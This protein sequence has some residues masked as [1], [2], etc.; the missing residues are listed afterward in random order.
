M[1]TPRVLGVDDFLFLP[2]AELWSYPHRSRTAGSHRLASRSRS[3][4]VQKVVACPSGCGDHQP[5]SRWR[6]CGRARQGA[7]KARQVADRWHLLKNLSEDDAELL[8]QQAITTQALVQ[9]SAAEASPEAENRHNFAPWHSGRTK[10]KARKESCVFISSESNVVPPDPG[11]GSQKDRV[12]TIARKLGVSRQ[13]VYT[14][15][16]MRQPPARTRIN[17]GG[18]R[19]IDSYKEYLAREVERGMSQCAADVS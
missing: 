10:R 15:L 6:V 17:Q 16:Q 7:P 5:G 14:Y 13:T 9:Q 18:K 2:P 1:P 8:S 11:S 12:A 19:L 3:R 4:D